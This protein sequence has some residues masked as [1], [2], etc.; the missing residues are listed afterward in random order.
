MHSRHTFLVATMAGGDKR[1]ADLP[2]RV[3]LTE[4]TKKART[5][6]CAHHARALLVP[7]ASGHSL[8]PLLHTDRP[9][10]APALSSSMPTL[11]NEDTPSSPPPGDQGASA[12]TDVSPLKGDAIDHIMAEESI[13]ISLFQGEVHV[14]SEAS[15]I[16]EA[17]L[18]IHH[19]NKSAGSCKCVAC[20]RE[21][22]VTVGSVAFCTDCSVHYQPQRPIIKKVHIC[23]ECGARVV[24]GNLLADARTLFSTCEEASAELHKEAIV[25]HED[26]CLHRPLAVCPG[27]T[28]SNMHEHCCQVPYC[29]FSEENRAALA[30]RVE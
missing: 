22:D 17:L 27:V 15:A 2:L 6:D 19:R 14:I 21:A 11:P 4:K 16:E 1:T 29:A 28:F 9:A 30:S 8:S 12:A 23:M 24:T 26:V 25:A 20:N 10:S 7:P 13:D 5:G 3:T 18:M